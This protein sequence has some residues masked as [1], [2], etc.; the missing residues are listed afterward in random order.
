MNT[1]FS[2]PIVMTVSMPEAMDSTPAIRV[3]RFQKNAASNG[4]ASDAPI[5][6]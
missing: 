3:T 6:V 1:A 2:I 5:I 4:G